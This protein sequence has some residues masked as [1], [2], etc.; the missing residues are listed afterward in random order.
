MLWLPLFFTGVR[1]DFLII[2]GASVYEIVYMVLGIGV[3]VIW[4][5]VLFWSFLDGVMNGVFC[6]VSVSSMFFFVNWVCVSLFL[7]GIVPPSTGG[8]LC[9]TL[10]I[11]VCPDL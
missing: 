6:L 11:G 9:W 3:S 2:V 5:F 10:L 7:V 1:W 8:V 4:Y